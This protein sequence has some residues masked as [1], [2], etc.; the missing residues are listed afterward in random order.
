M[1]TILRIAG[2]HK[3]GHSQHV[4]GLFLPW[5]G[6]H[7]RTQIVVACA[8]FFW[9]CTTCLQC[10]PLTNPPAWETFGLPSPSPMAPGTGF[11]VRTA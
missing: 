7:T 3:R 6:S 1:E 9:L 8:V 11:G 4:R 5:N 2:M 10:K